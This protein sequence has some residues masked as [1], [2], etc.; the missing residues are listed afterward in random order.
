MTTRSRDRAKRERDATLALSGINPAGAEKRIQAN[1]LRKKKRLKDD[2]PESS[3]G[4]EVPPKVE[5]H[6]N[7]GALNRQESE[8]AVLSQAA[9]SKDYAAAEK[10][11]YKLDPDIGDESMSVFSHAATGTAT[12]AFRGSETKKDWIVTDALLATHGNLLGHD[13]RFLH[14]AELLADTIGKYGQSNVQLTGHSLGGT[15]AVWFGLANNLHSNA[16]NPGSTIE[17]GLRAGFNSMADTARS[18]Y[19]VSHRE[20]YSNQGV[21]RISSDVVSAFKGSY[22]HAPIYEYS[23]H[24]IPMI[25]AH[26]L[27][28][29][30]HYYDPVTKQVVQQEPDS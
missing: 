21:H 20:N 27:T 30:E 11:G 14:H 28:Q 25:D 15:E 29:F 18:N 9:Y 24:G 5:P 7:S 13:P 12:V 1:E 4:A 26:S 2:V 17:P 22:K 23:R 6:N 8:H 3:K 19:G 10:L 16:F